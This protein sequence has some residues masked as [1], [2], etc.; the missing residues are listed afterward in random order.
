[1]KRDPRPNSDKKDDLNNQQQV[2]LETDS[3]RGNNTPREPGGMK[4][5]NSL[6]F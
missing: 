3:C 6:A 4:K 5:N 1:M 2:F